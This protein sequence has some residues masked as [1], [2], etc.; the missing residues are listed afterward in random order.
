[1]R[2]EI[3]IGPGE[4]LS[5]V[6]GEVHVVQRVVGGA[7][8]ELLGPVAGNH[9]AVVDENCPHLHGH[10]ESKIKISLN[11]ENKRENTFDEVLAK[12]SCECMV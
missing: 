2:T 3:G 9:V 5:V 7:V 8:D 10:E 11:G 1:M 6:D 12:W 4:V